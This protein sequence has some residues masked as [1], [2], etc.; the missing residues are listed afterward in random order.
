[1]HFAPLNHGRYKALFFRTPSLLKPGEPGNRENPVSMRVRGL[2]V[3]LFRGFAKP[4]NRENRTVSGFSGNVGK[5]AESAFNR[6]NRHGL[7]VLAAVNHGLKFLGAFIQG[8]RNGAKF[9]LDHGHE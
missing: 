9:F 2:P 7:I 3:L 4:G 8:F 6:L 5:N 1:M